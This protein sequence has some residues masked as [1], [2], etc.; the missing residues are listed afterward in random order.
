MFLTISYFEEEQVLELIILGLSIGRDSFYP[1]LKMLDYV[2]HEA[3][4]LIK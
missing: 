3:G 2:L 1:N 4:F